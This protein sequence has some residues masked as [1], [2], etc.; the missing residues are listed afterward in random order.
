MQGG[1]ATSDVHLSMKLHTATYVSKTLISIEKA[2]LKT[3]N[4]CN[5]HVYFTL[6]SIFK[7][8]TIILTCI[9]AFLR[10]PDLST[11]SVRSLEQ[12]DPRHSVVT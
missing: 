10:A 1:R 9:T 8:A 4:L 6:S 3:F 12:V 11:S 7:D 5:S 2:V